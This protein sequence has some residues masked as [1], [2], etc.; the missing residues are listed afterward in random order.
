MSAKHMLPMQLLV[1]VDNI[2]RYVRS[3][4][5]THIG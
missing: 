4:K 2:C 3:S 5:L 1:D